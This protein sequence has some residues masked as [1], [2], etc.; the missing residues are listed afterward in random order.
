MTNINKSAQ[1]APKNPIIIIINYIYITCYVYIG[2]IIYYS[3][4]R[5]YTYIFIISD[6]VCIY[7]LLLLCLVYVFNVWLPNLKRPVKG[8]VLK[9]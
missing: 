8:D 3:I 5:M 2:H 9:V 4:M 1:C 7:I 6:T